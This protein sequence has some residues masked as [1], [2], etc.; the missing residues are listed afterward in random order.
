[1]NVNRLLTTIVSAN[2]AGPFS[3]VEAHP[4][5]RDTLVV[6]DALVGTLLFVLQCSFGA[7]HF[8]TTGTRY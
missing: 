3:Y 1:M 7:S 2:R 5:G 8:A 6:C 4:A